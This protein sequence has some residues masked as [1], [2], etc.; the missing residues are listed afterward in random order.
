MAPE[1]AALH[2]ITVTLPDGA[3]RSFETPVTGAEIAA[4]IGAGLAKAALAI[5][6]DGKL[7]DLSHVIDRDAQIAIVTPKQPEA[8]ELIRHDAAH[9]MAEA[10]QELYPDTQVTIGPAIENGFYYDFARDEP[11][12]PDDLVEI[13]SE[14]A[15]DRRRDE[16]IVRE[17]WA[18]RR[19]DRLFREA[20]ARSTRPR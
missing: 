6:V 20:S 2:P 3:T 13:E 4:S 19:G 14:D 7:M 8:L 11:F 9:V 5:K 18:A 1:P 12:T 15:R 17:V 10:V 16:P